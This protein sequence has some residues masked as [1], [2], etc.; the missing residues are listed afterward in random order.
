MRLL[1]FVPAFAIALAGCPQPPIPPPVPPDASDAAP[2]PLGDAMAPVT[3][4]QAAC[5]ALAALHCPEGAQPD[6][7]TVLAHI[8]SARLVRVEAGTSLSC[9]AIAS[10]ATVAQARSQ[11]IACVQ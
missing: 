8:E 1:V 9:A 6:C 2:P 11:G 4:C 3:P 10:V 7:V 5:S